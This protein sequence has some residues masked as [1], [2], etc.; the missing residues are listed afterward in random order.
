M[1]PPMFRPQ[2][3]NRHA[4]EKG[5]RFDCNGSKNLGED[6]P[7]S[8]SAAVVERLIFRASAKRNL[9]RSATAPTDVLEPYFGS[10][11]VVTLMSINFH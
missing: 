11:S 2:I 10:S 9:A 6:E 5:Q 8:L 7:R 3:N 4:G 1:A